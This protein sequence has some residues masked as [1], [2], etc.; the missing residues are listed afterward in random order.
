MTKRVYSDLE[1]VRLKKPAQ[2]CSKKAPECSGEEI[3]AFV[4]SIYHPNI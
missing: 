2:E 3:E 4:S 1:K